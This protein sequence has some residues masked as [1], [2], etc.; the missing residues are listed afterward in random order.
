MKEEERR[1]TESEEKT[2]REVTM[3]Y[4]DGIRK[5]NE[6]AQCVG[7]FLASNHESRIK[8]S[9]MKT[10]QAAQHNTALDE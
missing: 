6:D 3:V 4:Q 9:R 10:G 7:M 8:A 5:I 1:E 2:K